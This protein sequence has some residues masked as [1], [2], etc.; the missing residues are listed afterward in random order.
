MVRAATNETK[1]A[2]DAFLS[3]KTE[4]ELAAS[5]QELRKLLDACS[6]KHGQLTKEAAMGQGFDRHLFAMRIIAERKARSADSSTEAP[7]TEAPPTEEEVKKVLPQLYTD[8]SYTDANK[9]VL[10]T[11]SL[12]GEFFSGG[13]FGPVVLDGF[14]LGYGY[15]QDR[16]GILC[17]SYKG[18]RDGN[19]LTNAFV[20]SLDMIRTVL[21]AN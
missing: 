13:G 10:S 17:S 12:Y 16:L 20:K 14:G 11:S 2:V 1:A 4:S 15:V 21:E 19:K 9:F 8:K 6:V 5:A 3:K 18:H 7:P